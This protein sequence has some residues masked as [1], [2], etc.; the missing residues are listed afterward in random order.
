MGSES[1]RE[2][3]SCKSNAL[4]TRL[5]ANAKLKDFMFPDNDTNEYAFTIGVPGHSFGLNFAYCSDDP[6]I[7]VVPFNDGI[8]AY[9]G[10]LGYANNKYLQTESELIAELLRLKQMPVQDYF[11]K[12]RFELIT[13]PRSPV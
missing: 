2:N 7:H 3:V 8:C 11:P 6:R 5:R 9:S 13:V 12:V 10:E 4:L 1:S